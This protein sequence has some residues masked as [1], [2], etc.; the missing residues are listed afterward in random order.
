[1]REP[2]CTTSDA[3]GSS[4]AIEVDT[5]LLLLPTSC[6][7]CSPSHNDSHKM[8]ETTT[9]ATTSGEKPQVT[10]YWSVP[11]SLPTLTRHCELNGSNTN[12]HDMLRLSLGL[13]KAVLSVSYGFSKNAKA[14]T[15]RLKSSSEAKTCLLVQ[16]SRRSIHFESHLS[17]LSRLPAR[18]SQLFL[19]SLELLQNIWSSTLHNI[20]S[21]SGIKPARRSR[22]AARLRNGCDIDAICTMPRVV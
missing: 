2:Y 7:S 6:S 19:P 22:L 16:S 21:Q 12:Q 9:P 4:E 3:T 14:W 20:L 15:T 11:M 8:A 10:L 17:S 5:V 1:M 18:L 13:S